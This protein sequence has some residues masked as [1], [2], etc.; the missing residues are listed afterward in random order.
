MCGIVAAV[1][2]E[3]VP[4]S[5]LDE[6][7]ASIQHRGPDESRTFHASERVRFDFHRLQINGQA[8]GAMQPFHSGPWVCVVNGEIYN[9]AELEARHHVECESGSDCEI[10]C[11]LLNLGVPPRTVFSNL[12]GVFAVAA[13]NRETRMLYAARDPFG[14]RS[15]YVGATHGG[16]GARLV[17][18]SEVKALVAAKCVHVAPFQPGHMFLFRAD[19]YTEHWERFSSRFEPKALPYITEPFDS[20]CITLKQHLEIAVRKRLMAERKP[21]GCFLSGGVDSSLIAGLVVRNVDD[22][23]GVHTFSIGQKGSPDLQFARMVA[24]HLGTT[25]HEVEVTAEE[26]LAAVEGTVRQFE[27]WDVTTIRAGTGH[28]LLAKYIAEKTEV[29]VVFSGEGADELF[30]SYLYFR[31]APSHDAFQEE[32][33]R[34]CRDLHRF[35]VLR[36]EKACAGHGLECRVPFLDLSFSKFVLRVPPEQRGY[37]DGMEKFMLRQAFSGQGVIPDEV[38]W[39]RKEA[40]SD[41]VTK[42]SSSWHEQMKARAGDVGEAEWIRSMFEARYEGMK[43]LIPYMWLP[44]WCGHVTDPSARVLEDYE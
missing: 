16:N 9:H 14:V 4:T 36:V 8:P 21:I 5:F 20:L 34:L 35:D 37:R 31:R 30:G 38:L 6:A 3:G 15:L 1:L 26:M 7:A 18:A 41:G 23:S 28:R 42:A 33:L 24:E 10:V 12:D 27:T 25:H 44:K 22:P 39:R 17:L 40:F 11:R 32:C 13:Y 2:H 29:R 19:D 43:K